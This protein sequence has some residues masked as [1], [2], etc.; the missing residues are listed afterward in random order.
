M[1]ASTRLRR[2]SC[3]VLDAAARRAL[4]GVALAKFSLAGL[5]LGLLAS[6]H[7]SAQA[8]TVSAAASLTNAFK[9]I[10]ARF[11]LEVPGA[12]L[13]FNFGASG[14]LLQQIAHGAPVDVYASADQATMDRGLAQSLFDAA[15]R[16]DFATNKL[17][18]IVPAEGVTGVTGV[19]D[20][21]SPEVRRIAVGKPAT[22][23][24][25]RYAK[26]ALSSAGAWDRLE[27]KLVY[28][29]NV[30]QVLDYVSRGE[31]AAGFVYAT[32]AAIMKDKV[33]AVETV[34]GD[35]PVS[36]PVAIVS[37][38]RQKALAARFIGFLATPPAREILARFGFDAP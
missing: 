10:G 12:T 33:K 5:A 9:E 7:A 15:S 4:A 29:D 14:V 18:L 21:E 36:Y 34:T 25:G 37:D 16:V 22:V 13:R 38:S 17:V 31:V 2:G 26:E 3:T 32:D 20:L 8:I 24:A 19:K 27:R 30:R 23:P 35:A 28:A 6:G 1:S 11:E